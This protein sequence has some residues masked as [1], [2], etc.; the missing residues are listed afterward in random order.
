MTPYIIG[1]SK[2]IYGTWFYFP[3]YNL[4]FDC[5]DGAAYTLGIHGSDVKHI[6][7][8]H[9]HSDHILGL[10]GIASFLSR[11]TKTVKRKIKVYY[12]QESQNDADKIILSLK[13]LGL[14][15]MFEFLTFKFG[16][17]INIEGNKFVLPFEVN[18]TAKYYK[19]PI[20]S[21]GFSI[22]EERKKLKPEHAEKIKNLSNTEKATYM[23]NISCK[24]NKCLVQNEDIYNSY[25][26]KYVTYCGDSLPVELNNIKQTE[27]LMHECTF[28]TQKECD[29]AHTDLESFINNYIKSKNSDIGKIILYH[30][31]EKYI[32]EQRDYK[33]IILNKMKEININTE[34]VEINKIYRMFN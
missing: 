9:F 34:I 10:F 7:I 5:G 30:I 19:K 3:T 26:Y 32:R 20:V 16:E 14:D 6:F 27:L 2:A 13:D 28:L 33:E 25:I 4:M 29:A 1:Q 24:D 23:K 15:K 11:A 17:K 31:S 22:C 8:S 18:H 21:C 12:N